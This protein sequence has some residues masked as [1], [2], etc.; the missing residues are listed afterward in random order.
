MAKWAIVPRSSRTIWCS[1]NWLSR[2]LSFNR[3]SCSA[4]R[5]AAGPRSIA[6]R[7]SA[8]AVCRL[9]LAAASSAVR[10]ATRCSSSPVEAQDLLRCA[11]RR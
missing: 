2:R 4:R 8:S 3:I 5:R 10:S 6:S 7:T 9:V 11:G 1:R